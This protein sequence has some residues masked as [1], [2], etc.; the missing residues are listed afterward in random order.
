MSLPIICFGQQPCGFFPKNYLVA[1]INTAKALQKKIGGSIVFF[2]HD[3]DAD[4]RET[5]TIMNDRQTDA[6]VRL[7]FLQENKIQKKFSPLY[8]KRIPE[9][10]KEEI[11]KQ[12]P[13]FVNKDLTDLFSS[14]EAK[15][16][17]DFCLEMYKKM[18]LLNDI[19]IVR[20]SDKQF[21]QEAS[22]IQN[23][24]FVDVEYQNEIVRAQFIDGQLKLHEGGGKYLNLPT[25]A[26]IEKWQKNPA[27][28]ERFGWMQSIIHCT[29]YIAGNSE[30]EY[31]KK[32]GF[33][34]AN[35]IKREQIENPDMAWLG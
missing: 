1:K 5:V 31:L 15:N 27:R 22:E 18:G 20:S 3:S 16:A 21:R 7:N 24:Y 8:L 10:W 35:F 9:G 25:P 30:F 29:H 4:Y 13:R 19:K 2:Y 17:A 12:L 6:E 28:D 33:P 23:E 32:E 26:K 11:I 34:E 14:I